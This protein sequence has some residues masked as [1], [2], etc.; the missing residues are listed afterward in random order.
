MKARRLVAVVFVIVVV[1]Q[2]ALMGPELVSLIVSRDGSGAAP[3][4]FLIAVL[5]VAAGGVA[6][7][8]AAVALFRK[9]NWRATLLWTVAVTALQVIVWPFG[10]IATL[11]G[12]VCLLHPEIRRSMNVTRH[13]ASSVTAA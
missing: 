7:L 13:R 12:L 10:P 1:L 11:V 2:F 4:L 6:S 8:I 5:W 9:W 3:T